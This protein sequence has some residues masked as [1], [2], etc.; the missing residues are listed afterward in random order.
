LQAFAGVKRARPEFSLV[1]VGSKSVPENLYR[2]SADLGLPP[3]RDVRFLLNLTDEL[4]DVYDGADLFISLSWRET[5]CLPALEA[6]TR[7]IP[8]VA[9]AWGATA[10]VV[11]DAARLVDPRDHQRVIQAI[12]ELSSAKDQ[13]NLALRARQ[14]ASRFDWSQTARQTQRL[15]QRL[16]G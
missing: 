11:G 9:S 3:G 13:P 10:E 14:A 5:F 2:R 8:V 4:T 12:F 6:L 1:L 16:A 7:G 15:Y